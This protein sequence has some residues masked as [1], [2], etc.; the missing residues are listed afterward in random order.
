MACI[1]PKNNNCTEYSSIH[2]LQSCQRS[3]PSD[4]TRYRAVQLIAVQQS[5][6]NQRDQLKREHDNQ[7]QH[8]SSQRKQTKATTIKAKTTETHASLTIT[9]TGVCVSAL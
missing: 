2:Y 5:I 1:K 9:A 7:Q 8:K 3:Q 6:I 4:L